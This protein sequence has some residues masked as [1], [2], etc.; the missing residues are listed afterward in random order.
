MS[1]KIKICHLTSVH[2]ALDNRIFY[3]EVTSL[4]RAGYEMSVI[5]IHKR[6]EVV[7]G[8]QVWGLPRVKRWQRPFIWF[9]LL[10]RALTV[11]AD[12]YH[13]HD[14]ELLFVTPLLR[15]L[16]RS[17]TIYDV[18]ESFADFLRVKTYLPRW[19][20]GFLATVYEW[21]EPKLA[22]D[23]SGLIFADEQ[24][25]KNFEHIDKPKAI[26]F[27]Y[28][29]TAFIQ[30]AVSQKAAPGNDAVLHLGM[31]ERNRGTLLMV[32]AFHQV[33]QAI[34]NAQLLLVGPFSSA[35]FEQE[36][37]AEIDRLQLESNITITNR[38]PFDKVSTYLQ[39][40]SVGWIPL[41][42]VQKYQKN[43]PTKIFEYMAYGLAIVASDLVP[44]R[45][46]MPNNDF[47]YRVTP[48][49][50][51]QHAL[52]LIALLR[53]PQKAREMGQRGQTAVM[54]NYNWKEM[55]TRLLEVYQEIFA[56]ECSK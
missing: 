12:L 45:T 44:I 9:R 8:I 50:P 54:K 34:P 43:I 38:V 19:I 30:R 28:P 13:F 53:D 55:E 1:N 24:I 48:S 6:D 20:R 51:N 27:N 31:H 35:S 16:T 40:S 39:Q 17:F 14:P 52:A 41:Q 37:R 22:L 11:H 5:G 42:P 3:R 36:V 29:S 33:V 23:Q 26:L 10:Q 4:H 15:L 32:T 56:L 7:N 25:A 2:P 18:H 21:L 46:Y 49:D 47:G